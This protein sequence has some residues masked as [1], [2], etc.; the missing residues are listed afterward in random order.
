MMPAGTGAVSDLLAAIVQRLR[1]AGLDDAPRESRRILEA[2]AGITAEDQ[3]RDPS[4]VLPVEDLDRIDQVV[5]RRARG[6][7][8]SRILGRRN[9]YGRDFAIGPETLDPRPDTEVVVE[10]A[11]ELLRA[12][13]RRNPA[14]RILDIGTGSGCIA[15]TLCL[16]VDGVRGIATD[17]SVETLETAATNAHA[18]GVADRLG[19]QKADGPAAIAGPFDLVISNP[20]YIAHADIPTLDAVV[21][22]HDPVRALDGG[23]DGLSFYRDW[24]PEI[25]ARFPQAAMVLEVGAGQADEVARLLRQ[26]AEGEIFFR[27]DLG[28]HERCVAAA[29]V[30]L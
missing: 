18:L 1:A 12:L 17:I 26:H 13:A 14:P 25:A 19:F 6:E 28:G 24:I 15:I 2:A 16:E 10:T 23:P 20:P 27:R 4:R 21:R 8:L 3:L 22:D 5:A 29:P 11:I 30:N 9:F 7:P